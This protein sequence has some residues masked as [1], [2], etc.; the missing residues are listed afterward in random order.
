MQ[1]PHCDPRAP[2]N[3]TRIIVEEDI[4]F[5][6]TALVVLVVKLANGAK[7]KP[8]CR[9]EIPH[10][11]LDEWRMLWVKAEISAF[12]IGHT[13]GDVVC[14]IEGKVVQSRCKCGAENCSSNE[15]EEQKNKGATI[16]SRQLL[17]RDECVPHALTQ[18]RPGFTHK[19]AAWNSRLNAWNSRL[20]RRFYICSGF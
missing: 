15:Q 20:K 2:L 16:D 18:C 6:K 14:L 17:A 11:Q 5:G 1:G 13:S 10:P 12:H 19:P 8:R 7:M 4:F 3:G 9:H